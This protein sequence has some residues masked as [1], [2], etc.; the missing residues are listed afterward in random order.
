MFQV[1]TRIVPPLPLPPPGATA[2]G[3]VQED[4]GGVHEGADVSIAAV[5]AVTAALAG[6]APGGNQPPATQVQSGPGRIVVHPVESGIGIG[7]AVTDAASG[8]VI[9]G[10][11]QLPP[12]HVHAGPGWTVVHAA[13]ALVAGAAA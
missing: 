6:A 2:A 8:S 7:A 1:M 13:G 12:W 4:A 9:P 5:V 10:G 3:G 11:Y